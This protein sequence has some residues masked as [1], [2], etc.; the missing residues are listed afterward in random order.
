MFSPDQTTTDLIAMHTSL[1]PLQRGPARRAHR[2]FVLVFSAAVCLWAGTS[3]Q[4]QLSGVTGGNLGGAGNG[5]GGAFFVIPRVNVAPGF[6]GRGIPHVT[7]PT[8]TQYAGSA[9]RQFFA[10]GGV[11]LG[12]APAITAPVPAGSA[13][14]LYAGSAQRPRPTPAPRWRGMV[15][16]R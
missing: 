11:N 12:N 8:P 13:A 10:S 5:R 16:M 1:L 3:A 2:V 14:P 15:V 7:V 4:A 9:A 6:G